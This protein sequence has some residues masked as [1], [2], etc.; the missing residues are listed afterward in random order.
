MSAQTPATPLFRRIAFAS[1]EYE[2]ALDLRNRLLRI[3]LGLTC[4]A[5]DLEAEASHLHLAGFVKNRLIATLQLAPDDQPGFLKMRQVAVEDPLQGQGIG[6]HL[7]IFAENEARTHGAT[8]LIL[9]A[10][11]PVVPFYES[12]G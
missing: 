10:R 9:N 3:P 11:E 8:T 12:L 1:P 6:R 5:E 2:Q 4:E 7:I